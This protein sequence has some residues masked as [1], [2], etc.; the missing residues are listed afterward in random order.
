MAVI[1]L[2]KWD[3]APGIYVWKYPSDELSNL[4]Q[5][6]VSE[7]QQAILLKD[8]KLIGIFGA[9]RYTLDTNN[10]PLLS[11][12]IKMPFGGHSPFKAEVWF[13]NKAITLDVK[14][15]TPDP[16]QLMDPKYQVML[17]VRAFGQFGVQ[18]ENGAKFLLKIVGTLSRYDSNSL[19]T[20]FKGIVI[21]KVKDSIAKKLVKEGIS[22][23]EVNA[24]LSAIS[25]FLQSEIQGD[26]AEFGVQ[27]MHFKVLSIN[28][29]ENDPAVQ[30]LKSAL[31][32]KAEM[33]IIGY[34]YQ[35]ERSFNALES[36]AGNQGSGGSL[37]GAGIGMGVGLG[38]GGQMG[39][40]SSEIAQQMQVSPPRG[41]PCPK[42]G[43]S[44]P[45]TTKFCS[46]CGFSMVR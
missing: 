13:V 25:D 40:A 2:V 22:I 6:I 43:T 29:P 38:M 7:S 21:T 34:S 39:R 8:G 10:I 42:C 36:A 11:T 30:K 20:H 24:S 5:L 14:W 46:G 32:K 33:N 15:G 27:L 9:G 18:I 17:P 19:M 1:D 28:T 26:M 31:A 44:V 23:L 37:M 16:I 12:F 45:D 4:T 35:Q 3:S 41:T